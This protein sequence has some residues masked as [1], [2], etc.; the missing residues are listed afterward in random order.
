MLGWL[1]DC[2]L[3]AG[4]GFLDR[5]F[6]Q[7]ASFVNFELAAVIHGHEHQRLLRA[8]AGRFDPT[9]PVSSSIRKVDVMIT[10]FAMTK[11]TGA[12]RVKKARAHIPELK[13]IVASG[14]ADLPEGKALDMPRLAK[15]YTDAEIASAIAVLF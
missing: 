14:Y 3:P 9:R 1:G 10:D 12:E 11:M 5:E 8:E 6:P 2:R 13:V 15:P 7:D 4:C